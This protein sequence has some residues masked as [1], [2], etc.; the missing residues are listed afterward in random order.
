[1][2]A[3]P[4]DVSELRFFRA[5]GKFYRIHAVIFHQP[6]FNKRP[7]I[8]DTVDVYFSISEPFTVVCTS[9]SETLLNESVI[10]TEPVR[11]DQAPAFGFSGLKNFR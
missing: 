5:E 4:V 9:G 2:V 1:M 10:T 7:E 6:F 3:V 11:V 8:F